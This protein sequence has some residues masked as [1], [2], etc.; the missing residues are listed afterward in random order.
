ML[1][2]EWGT[3][4]KSD[5]KVC[6]ENRDENWLRAV[7]REQWLRAVFREQWWRLI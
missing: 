5:V 4:V 3:G 6:V 2:S 1:S 7:C